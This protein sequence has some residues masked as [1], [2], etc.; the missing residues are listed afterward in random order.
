MVSP[1]PLDGHWQF[2]YRHFLGDPNIHIK[3]NHICIQVTLMTPKPCDPPAR[4]RKS[5]R[6]LGVYYTYRV[7]CSA[8]K[9]HNQSQSI[10]IQVS[11]QDQTVFSAIASISRQ[12][13]ICS[14]Y[15]FSNL[16]T[17]DRAANVIQQFECMSLS[18]IFAMNLV[19]VFW[20]CKIVFKRPTEPW[21]DFQLTGTHSF[22]RK[23]VE[24]RRGMIRSRR[25]FVNSDR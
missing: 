14:S 24:F 13:R 16:T 11:F 25:N 7:K 5:V 18:E 19:R 4:L 8:H 22:S 6:A 15:V 20:P 3:N 17:D 1:W 9:S 21:A 12:W 2:N 10:S 23:L